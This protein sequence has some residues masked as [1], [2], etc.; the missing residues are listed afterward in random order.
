M[1]EVCTN[2]PAIATI[3]PLTLYAEMADGTCVTVDRFSERATIQKLLGHWSP[4]RYVIVSLHNT[5][6]PYVSGYVHVDDDEDCEVTRLDEAIE[7]LQAAREV[8]IATK[9]G[10]TAVPA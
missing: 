6:E 5:G 1:N 8:F 2:P 3:E 9:R 4:Q 7:L 10:A